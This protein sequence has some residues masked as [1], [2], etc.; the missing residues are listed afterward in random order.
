MFTEYHHDSATPPV[1]PG[2]FGG[3]G[4]G[5]PISK[6]LVELHGGRMGVD[7]VLGVGA[8]FWFTLPTAAS[9]AEQ[10]SQASGVERPHPPSRT[11]ERV[12][13]LDQDDAR[14][15]LFLQGHLRNFRI[16][17]TPNRQAAIAAAVERRA[18]AIL[19]DTAA[20]AGPTG[21]LPVPLLRLPLPHAER[22]ADAL[23]VAAYLDKPVSRATLH[24][25]ISRLGRPIRRVLV[26]DDDPRFVRLMTRMLLAL[27]QPPEIRSAH[28]G[29]EAL[30]ILAAAPPDL[31]LLD[32]AMP[33]MGGAELLRQGPAAPGWAEMAVFV[34]S[35]QDQVVAG[36]PL[37]GQVTIDKPDGW[38]LEELLNATEALFAVL[39]PP[40]RYLANVNPGDNSLALDGA[41]R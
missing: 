31:L 13:I 33:E 39:D 25:A 30:A 29:R 38:R 5:L 12:L 26:V 21:E 37:T 27:P 18:V 14:L 2:Q 7:S 32:L 9:A 19:G 3:I 40:R 8:T 41:D 36:L 10:A 11:T 34:I 15:S 1:A 17:A 22:L 28:N 35:G 24:S 16:V 6:R 20:A 4:L 23:G